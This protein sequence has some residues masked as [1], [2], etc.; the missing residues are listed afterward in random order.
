ME[1]P[2]M[3]ILRMSCP[4]GVCK[5][6]ADMGVW[7][8]GLNVELSWNSSASLDGEAISLGLLHSSLLQG[9]GPDDTNG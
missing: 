2:Q 4:R 3:R 9:K 5:L 8:W 7:L 1:G 6:E